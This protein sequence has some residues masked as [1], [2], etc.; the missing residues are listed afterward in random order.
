MASHEIPWRNSWSKKGEQK[1]GKTGKLLVKRH[2]SDMYI[3]YYLL[4]F[5][6]DLIL[7]APMKG[8]S[9]QM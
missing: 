8:V 1:Q 3:Y 9:R 2:V 7:S 6:A 4:G 5:Q